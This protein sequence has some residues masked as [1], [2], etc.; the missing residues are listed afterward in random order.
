MKLDFCV[1][2]IDTILGSKIN[3]LKTSYMFE[4]EKQS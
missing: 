3:I 4:E 1:H 2:I